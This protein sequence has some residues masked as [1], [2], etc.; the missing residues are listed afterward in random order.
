MASDSAVTYKEY[1]LAEHAWEGEG[2]EGLKSGKRHE[3][4]SW[5]EPKTVQ[6]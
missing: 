6:Y 3:L 2:V 4:S 5:V 1:L